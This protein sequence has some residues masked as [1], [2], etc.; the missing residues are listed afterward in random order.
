MPFDK[1]EYYKDRL[2][3]IEPLF[4]LKQLQFN[5]LLEI[6]QAV[7][8]NLPISALVR[9][10]EGIIL[11]QFEIKRNALI[12]KKNNLEWE[13]ISYHGENESF[14]KENFKEYVQRYKDIQYITA[15]NSYDEPEFEFVIPITLKGESIAYM[16]VGDIPEDRLNTKEEKIKFIQIISNIICVANENKRL[17]DLEVNQKLI[18][19]DLEL[20]SE[21]QRLL[22]PRKFP[23]N[24]TFDIAAFYKPFRGI[25]GDYYD[26]IPVS[27]YEYIFCMCDI[28]GKG[29]AAAMLM[30]NFQA[31]LRIIVKQNLSLKE[32]VATL[33]KSVLDLT[34]GESFITVFIGLIN[35][36]TMELEYINAGHNPSYAMID[37]KI[38]SLKTGCTIL[39]AFDKLP[40][41]HSEKIALT[42]S[43]LIVSYTDGITES[44][45]AEE[46]YY[47]EERLV[48][49]IEKNYEEAPSI[50]NLKLIDEI[51]NFSK[52]DVFDD[53]LSL[54]TIR[55]L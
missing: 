15:L 50:F 12:I 17:T 6:T 41:I 44:S 52:K 18:Q 7:N 54:L 49:F 9:I 16:L 2:S 35:T 5:Q 26:F 51:V 24:E 39:G 3:V 46:E 11:A 27:F 14:L 34:K 28:S 47:G 23:K 40:F 30:A 4:S 48:P 45:N 10:L 20:A 55:I 19:K 22:I 43:S 8:Y 53:D 25:G 38:V 1:I 13:C 32:I 37:K 33:N 36:K 29:I 31:N 21:I 42:P